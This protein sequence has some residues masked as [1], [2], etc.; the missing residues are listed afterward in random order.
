M[1][2]RKLKPQHRRL[3]YAIAT[4][5]IPLYTVA[6]TTNSYANVPEKAELYQILGNH[7]LS[8]RRGSNYGPAVVGSFLQK[9]Y[10]TLFLP[11]NGKSFAQ[12]RF[13]NAAGKDMGLQLQAS[14]KN[15]QLTLYYLPCTAKQ[16]D[17][18]LIEWANQGSG[19]RA[20][21]YGV[22]V[23]RGVRNQTKFIDKNSSN[24]E[25]AKQLLI[26]QSSGTKL[27]YC[28]VAAADGRGWSGVS[29]SEPCDEPI[30]QCLTSGG[31]ECAAITRDEWSL[32]NENLIA[33]VNCANNQSFS[34]KSSGSGMKDAVAKLWE[35]SQNQKAKFCALHV[36]NSEQDEVIVAPKIPDRNLFQTRNTPNGIQ[37]DVIAG[38]A[39]VISAKNPQGVTLKPGQKYNYN[40]ENQEDQIETFDNQVESIELQ[41]YQA[42]ARGLKLCDQEQVSGG[43]QGDS[44]EIQLTANEGQIN[45]SYEMYNVPDRLKVSYE[46]QTLIDTDFVSG[47]NKV[48]AKF[49][50][51]SG[52]VKVEVIG[53]KDISTTQWKYT[54]YC[55]Q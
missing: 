29:A 20:C 40:G 21:E 16:G 22:R 24:I 55:P 2:N 13:Q 15:K 23:Q 53:N 3:M 8:I 50:G 6:T 34:E 47:S 36:I 46:G 43:Q 49:K 18:L 37:V 39:S 17:S 27:Q 7:E 44:R 38:I 32:R 52:R 41:V 10:D 51:N 19:K 30:Q 25:P 45:I 42:E 48:S 1:N 31:K 5:M 12:L 33:T 14:T 4:F 54:L 11:G 26:A 28:S 9:V 35:Q